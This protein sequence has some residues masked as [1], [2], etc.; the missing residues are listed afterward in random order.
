MAITQCEYH[1]AIIAT[2]GSGDVTKG[3]VIDRATAIARRSSGGDVVV[4]GPD[5]RENRREASAIETAACGVGNVIRHGAHGTAGSNALNH[6]Q[7][8]VPPP[9]GHCFYETQGRKAKSS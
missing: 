6:Y 2:D 5:P 4:C 8:K 1:E 9:R 7:A 3:A